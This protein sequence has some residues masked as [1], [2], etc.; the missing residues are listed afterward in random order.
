MKLLASTALVCLASACAQFGGDTV[1]IQL[2]DESSKRGLDYKYRAGGTAAHRLPEIMG[3]GVALFD[4]EQDGD[5]D[6]YFIQSGSLDN[7]APEYANVL[8][9]NDGSGRFKPH[10]GGDASKNIGFGMGIAV[11]DVNDDKLPDLFITQL[12]RNVL[13]LNEGENRFSDISESAGFRFD[14]WSTATAFADFDS[15]GD[16]DLWV[17]NYIE[18]SEAIEPECYQMM[19]GSR[20]YC[21]PSHY[22]APAQDR[23]FRN[24]GNGRFVDVTRTAGVFG[25]KGN[26][27]GIVTADFNDDG[28]IDIFVANDTSPNNL[29]INQGEFRFLDE[30]EVWNCAVDQH[31]VARAGMGIVATDLDDDRDLDVMVVH[32]TTEP[33][34]VF[35]NEGDYFRD[36]TA[37]VGLSIYTQRYTR[38]GLVVDDLD[39][40]GWL[41]VF[42]ANGAVTR[43]SKPHKGDKFAEPN[44][45]Y[46]GSPEGRFELVEYTSAINTSR[47]AAVGD[48][49]N[50]GTLEIVLVDRDQPAKLLV[51]QATSDANWLL[52]DVRDRFGRP[53]IGASI[54]IKVGERT[55]SR[56]VQRASSYLS[57]RDPRLHFG[58]GN[59]KSIQNV[60]VRWLSGTTRRI[61]ALDAN[62]IVVIQ[63]SNT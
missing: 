13:L 16:L 33:D 44:S 42:E 57:S 22:S 1:S 60:E 49:D 41:D 27:L 43:L 56:V 14:D 46:R 4:S 51:N 21:S 26:G 35:Q 37:Q 23:V 5:L 53:A 15:D 62:Q 39:N 47:G 2:E 34:Y 6:V 59:A 48:I 8:F 45:L 18:W 50:D 19:L 30:A 28:L 32:I 52:F 12:G 25:V 63:E 20:D 7:Q 54:S 40:D 36:V 17:V 11:G 31:G 3:G 58:L 38:F 61:D 55:I 9:L 29:W 24:D 10:D